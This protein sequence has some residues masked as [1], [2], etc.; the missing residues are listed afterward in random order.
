LTPGGRIDRRS[1]RGPVGV[2][3]SVFV[4]FVEEHPEFLPIVLPLF[5]EADEGH[6]DIVTSALTL[7]EALVVPYRAGNRSLA[8]R[9]EALWTRGRGVR[10][11]VSRG[12]ACQMS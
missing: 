2:D 5:R 8:E 7:L 10:L 4:Y 3:T 9:Y 6:R 11:L 1:G 12:P